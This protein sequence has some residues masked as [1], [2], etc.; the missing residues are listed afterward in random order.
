MRTD[1]TAEHARELLAYEPSTG[2]LTWRA[3]PSAVCNIVIGARAG[4]RRRNGYRV[5]FINRRAYLEHRLAWLVTF[6]EWPAGHLDHI[7]RHRDDNRIANLRPASGNQNDANRA[8]SAICGLK[9]ASF[10][11][12]WKKWKARIKVGGKSI[13]LGYHDTPEQ[14]HA[15]YCRAAAEHFGEYACTA[16]G[17]QST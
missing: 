17:G 16:H 12:R 9:G 5:I 1:L 13:W 15:A 10:D 8:G 3:K 7:N 6:G 4:S 14:A 2:F 11:R